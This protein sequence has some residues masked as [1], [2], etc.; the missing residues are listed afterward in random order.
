[1]IF[2]VMTLGFIFLLIPIIMQETSGNPMIHKMG[3]DISAGNMEGKE[4][5]FGSFYSAFYCAE[6]T[7]ISAGTVVIGT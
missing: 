4:A 2:A 1:M 5:R 3:V 7:V 6:N